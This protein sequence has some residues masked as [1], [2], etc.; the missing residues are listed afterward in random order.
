MTLTPSRSLSHTLRPHIVLTSLELS[1]AWKTVRKDTGE[2]DGHFLAVCDSPFSTTMYLPAEALLGRVTEQFLVH[3]LVGRYPLVFGPWCKA[4]DLEAEYFSPISRSVIEILEHSQ[5]AA[6][7]SKYQWLMKVARHTLDTTF[8]A[9]VA[10]IN[11]HLAE[12]AV[13]GAEEEQDDHPSAVQL[14]DED[15]LCQVLEQLFRIGV[16]QRRPKL[17]TDIGTLL[18]GDDHNL[19]DSQ[20]N[21]TLEGATD[22]PLSW[23]DAEIADATA[24][25]ARPSQQHGHMTEHAPDGRGTM[26][27]QFPEGD[28]HAFTEHMCEDT[29]LAHGSAPDS[30]SA[31][32]LSNPHIGLALDLPNERNHSG[33]ITTPHFRQTLGP[34]CFDYLDAVC[35]DLDTVTRHHPGEEFPFEELLEVDSIPLTHGQPDVNLILD[36]NFSLD[37]VEIGNTP[38][39]FVDV[40][41]SSDF[42]FVLFDP[43]DVAEPAAEDSNTDLLVNASPTND[44]DT[45]RILEDEWWDAIETAPLCDE[46]AAASFVADLWVL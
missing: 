8:Q 42:D 23:P 17:A 19:I 44:D 3:H 1:F 12:P 6:F 39:P 41:L 27:E 22:V 13:D 2:W 9:S 30:D 31:T 26:E 14:S 36:D 24:A 34:S 15:V 21:A 11:S 16:P 35:M 38:R 5:N 20:D 46:D 37:D 40:P 45:F 32:P 10:A 28:N 33:S 4:L 25:T 18:K 7:R 43:D 29:C